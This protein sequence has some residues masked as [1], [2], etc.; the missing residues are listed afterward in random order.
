VTYNE[1]HGGNEREEESRSSRGQIGD[2]D[3]SQKHDHRVTNLVDDGSTAEGRD[4]ARGG[5]DDRTDDVKQNT[6]NDEFESTE[7]VADFG[8]SRLGGSGND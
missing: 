7:D 4:S 8:G 1:R 2:D 6:D 5:F 3:F